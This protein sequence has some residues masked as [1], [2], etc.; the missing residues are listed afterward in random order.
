MSRCPSVS[1]TNEATVAG[2]YRSHDGMRTER[3][4][5]CYGCAE[6]LANPANGPLV[7]FL[8]EPIP[9]PSERADYWMPLHP[10][11]NRKVPTLLAIDALAEWIYTHD[12]DNRVLAD[13]HDALGWRS[14]AGDPPD[15]ATLRA[16]LQQVLG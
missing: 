1:C 3:T 7:F 15:G 2:T 8:D 5:Y 4:A 6:L 14:A 16:R 10:A 9:P 11:V 13:F 12:P